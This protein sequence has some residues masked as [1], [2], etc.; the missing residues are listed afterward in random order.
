MVK[1]IPIIGAAAV[2]DAAFAQVTAILQGMLAARPDI[3]D[4]MAA[5][6]IKVGIL[7]TGDVT[8]DLPEYAFLKD[9]AWTDWDARA[10]GLGAAL[11]VPLTSGAEEN[12]LYLAKDP[13]KGES[14]FLHEFAHSIKA[15]GIVFLGPSF[16]ER[17]EAA[18][19]AAMQ[20]DLWDNTYVA[21]NLEEYWAEGVQS[22]FDVN[23]L[24]KPSNGI[25][26]FVETREKLKSH[27]PIHY[28]IVEEKFSTNWRLKFDF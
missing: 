19:D 24:V 14:I 12:L 15:L 25:K 28:E 3:L 10:R 22:Y 1:G 9:D 6:N 13:Y 27:D 2:P 21:V 4:Q 20:E 5:N 17:L 26:N 7:G 16:A 23:L 11:A 18:Y 8:T